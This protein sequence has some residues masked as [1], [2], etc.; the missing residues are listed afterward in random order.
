[1]IIGTER[2]VLRPVERADAPRFVALCNDIDIARNTAR[3]PQP[4]TQDDAARF[5]ARAA[6]AVMQYAFEKRGAARVAAGYF[7]DNPA[8]RRVL[9]KIGLRHTGET[10]MT[11]SVGRGCAAETARMALKRAAFEPSAEIAYA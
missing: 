6:R 9:E 1:M 3:I 8:S 7:I 2:L 11:L 5:V 4:Y 10:V